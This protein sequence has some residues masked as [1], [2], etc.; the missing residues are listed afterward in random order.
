[1]S[2]TS[3]RIFTWVQVAGYKKKKLPCDQSQ[4]QQTFSVRGG[5][6]PEVTVVQPLS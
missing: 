1:M 4:S 3:L 2:S 6:A 5:K